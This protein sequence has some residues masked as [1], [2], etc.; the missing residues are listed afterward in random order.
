M[1]GWPPYRAPL[2]LWLRYACGAPMAPQGSG[3]MLPEAPVGVRRKGNWPPIDHKL[4]AFPV[5]LWAPAVSVL[6][7]INLLSPWCSC[8]LGVPCSS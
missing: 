7:Y 3:E 5:Y 1:C 4:K 8:F 6:Y 2:R